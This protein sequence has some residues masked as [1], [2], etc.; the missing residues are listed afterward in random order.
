MTGD[1]GDVM[2]GEDT[3]GIDGIVTCAARMG[4]ISTHCTKKRKKM[5]HFL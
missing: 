3:V 5:V 1:E 4:V 2:E